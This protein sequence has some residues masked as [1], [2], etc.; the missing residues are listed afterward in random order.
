MFLRLN[1][2]LTVPQMILN[3]VISLL[4]IKSVAYSAGENAVSGSDNDE[5]EEEIEEVHFDDVGKLF[6]ISATNKTTTIRKSKLGNAS[7]VSEEQFTGF[8]VAPT[9]RRL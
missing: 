1:L 2:K 5:E 6:D 3:E 8:Y 9:P 4:L 7:V